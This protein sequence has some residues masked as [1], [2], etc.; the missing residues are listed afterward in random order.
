MARILLADN[1]P[2][3]LRKWSGFLRDEG[4]EVLLADSVH[5]ADEALRKG[6]LD[7]AILDLHMETDND[8]ND[9]SGFFLAER[10]KGSVETIMLTG[11]PGA[12]AV[13]EALNRHD[14][15]PT[16]LKQQG[17]KPLLHAIQRIITPKVFLSHGRNLGVVA[18]VSKFLAD[19]GV[20]V[21]VL[22]EKAGEGQTISQKFENYSK[23]NFAIVLITPDDV[24]RE[25]E[26]AKPRPR[27]R[28]NVIFELGFFLGRLDRSRVIAL[29]QGKSDAIDIPSN[30]YGVQMIEID[31]AGGWRIELAR[32]MHKAGIRI[33]LNSVII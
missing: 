15:R 4:H 21:I 20:Q 22:R 24:G 11:L 33:D 13:L 2:D 28:Q 29:C 5:A 16:F 32:E 1:N 18:M 23:V 10:Y 3:D 31:P 27:A 12:D 19:G 8:Q 7:L 9:R 6:D 14:L 17:P 30:Y 25:L 26:E